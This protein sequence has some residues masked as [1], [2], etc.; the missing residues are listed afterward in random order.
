MVRAQTRSSVSTL[1]AEVLLFLLVEDEPEIP[2]TL[3]YLSEVIQVGHEMR[4]FS[5]QLTDADVDGMLAILSEPS[6]AE[7]MLIAS[8]ATSEFDGEADNMSGGFAK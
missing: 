3:E 5:A 4:A 2:R 1:R 6:D 7:E 8:S